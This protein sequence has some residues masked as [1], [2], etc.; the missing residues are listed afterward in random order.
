MGVMECRKHDC[1]SILCDTYIDEIGY[2]CSDCQ[3]EF[4]QYLTRLNHG[5]DEMSE[6]NFKT[7]LYYF[8][9]LPKGSF[10]EKEMKSVDDF[11]AE[12]THKE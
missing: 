5:I 8:M 4:K 11:F 1:E 7:Q 12:H 9:T 3:K 2:V 10:S 6:Q